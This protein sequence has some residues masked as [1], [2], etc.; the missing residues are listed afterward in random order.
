MLR[1]FCVA[2]VLGA[3]LVAAHPTKAADEKE[4]TKTNAKT[5]D[6][7]KLFQKIDTNNDG[8]LSKEEVAN[9]FALKAKAKGKGG[10]GKG[11][12]LF[13]RLDTN[14]DGFLSL[15][16]FENRSQLKAKTRAKTKGVKT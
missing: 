10:E 16:E 15:S 3:F 9:F 5:K 6:P 4:K 13:E 11:L 12:K 14:K 2:A 8:K 1:D 7:A